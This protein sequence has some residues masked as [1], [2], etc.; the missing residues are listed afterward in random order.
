MPV[1]A[2]T[3]PEYFIVETIRT[4]PVSWEPDAVPLVSVEE[5]LD[6]VPPEV[7]PLTS[8]DWLPKGSCGW[9]CCPEDWSPP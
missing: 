5:P 1:P 6:A 7:S 2:A 3:P 8:C 9:V 4:R